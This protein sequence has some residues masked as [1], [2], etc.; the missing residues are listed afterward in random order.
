MNSG[1]VNCQNTIIAGNATMYEPVDDPFCFSCPTAAGD[2]PDF[3]GALTSQGYNLIG[4]TKDTV[5]LGITTGNLLN[6]DPLLGPL[7]DNGGPTVTHALLPGSPAIDAGSSGGLNTDQRGVPRPIDIPS[8]PNAAD[9]SDIGAYEFNS[10]APTLNIA[11]PADIAAHNDPGQ[12]SAVVNY[13]PPLVSGGTGNVTV[14]CNPASGSVFPA[15]TTTATCTA[16]DASGN[17]VACSFNVAIK[18]PEPP[19]ASCAVV[20]TPVLLSKPPRIVGLFQLLA[21]DNCDPDPL[22]Y[23]K[24][25]VG[26]FVAGPFHNG[27]RVEIAHCPTL[28]PPGRQT[29]SAPLRDIGRTAWCLVPSPKSHVQDLRQFNAE[30]GVKRPPRA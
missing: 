25:S 21:T 6:L 7:Q 1:T 8:L 11:C 22:I 18:D 4:N 19:A 14:V 13:P 3:L 24:G 28:I 20:K 30:S 26:S 15:G 9:G 10:G 29:R 23:V 16:T 27:D 5:I 12:C 2:A 17:T